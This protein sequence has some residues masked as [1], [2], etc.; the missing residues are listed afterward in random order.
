MKRTIFLTLVLLPF[1]L[2][3]QKY[4]DKDM[5][6]VKK[7]LDH[8]VVKNSSLH[9]EL[10]VT[11]S[12]LILAIIETDTRPTRFI[13]GF[14]SESGKCN[15][16]RTEANCEACYKK[17]LDNLLEQKNHQWKKLNENQ[18][19]SRYEDQMLV[20]LAPDQN[21]HSFTVFRA[22]WSRDFYEL[23]IKE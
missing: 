17:Y 18:Y 10:T 1:S 13:Y 4:F 21:E 5:A 7:E 15:F 11:D 2:F 12:S 14:D 16:Q 19:I 6:K 20:E 22:H 23:L 3:A 9:P 8:Y